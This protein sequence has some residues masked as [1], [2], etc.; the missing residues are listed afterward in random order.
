MFALLVFALLGIIYF[1]IWM[2]DVREKAEYSRSYAIL[3]L[4]IW[5]IL[6]IVGDVIQFHR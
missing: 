2:H 6:L 3:Y 1:C 5:L 4:I